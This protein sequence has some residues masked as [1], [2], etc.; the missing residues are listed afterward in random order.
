MLDRINAVNDTTYDLASRKPLVSRV[1][2]ALIDGTCRFRRVLAGV[3]ALVIMGLMIGGPGACRRPLFYVLGWL[4]YIPLATFALMPFVDKLGP[5]I[6]RMV[7]E[8]EAWEA[9]RG[10]V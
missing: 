2:R 5:S 3:G 8:D 4:A 7:E 6:E 1:S 10:R 9:H